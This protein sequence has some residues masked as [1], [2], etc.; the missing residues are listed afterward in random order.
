MAKRRESG[1]DFVATL[2]WPAGLVVGFMAFLAIQFG[3]RWLAAA[4]DNPILASFGKVAGMGIFEPFAW[5]FLLACCGAATASFF[6]RRKRRQLLS[7]QTGMD[8]LR[9][10]D[11]RTF[12]RLVGEAFRRQG[13]AVEE[14]GQEAQTAVSTCCCAKMA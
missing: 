10:M 5:L 2:S 14:T 6:N 7:A 1:I 11:W 8:S 9:H 4:S 3:I 12:E 13:Y